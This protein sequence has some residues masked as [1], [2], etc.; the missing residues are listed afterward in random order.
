MLCQHR[1]STHQVVQK[2]QISVLNLFSCLIWWERRRLSYCNL[3]QLCVCVCVAQGCAHSAP[4]GQLWTSAPLLI[5]QACFPG[6]TPLPFPP[7]Y[8]YGAMWTMA[9]NLLF[10]VSPLILSLSPWTGPL[11]FFTSQSSSVGG[12]SPHWEW[13]EVRGCCAVHKAVSTLPTFEL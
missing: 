10:S 1:D 13:D 7:P 8:Y 4:A 6:L 2:V 12:L 11:D 3:S 9:F 5:S